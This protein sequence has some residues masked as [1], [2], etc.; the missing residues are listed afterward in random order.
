MTLIHGFRLIRTLDIPEIRSKASLY[1]HE[2]TKGEVLSLV[3]DDENK[4]FGISF[5]TPPADSTGLPHILEHSVLCGSRKYPVKEPFVELLKGSLQT[6]LN[7]FTFPD[8]TCYPVAST[9]P[10]DFENLI[11]VY[12][13]AVFHPRITPDTLRQEGWRLELPRGKARPKLMGVVYN[14]MKGAY[15]SPDNL[16][17][18]LSQQS[19]FPDTPYG[20]DSGG[21]PRRIPDLTFENFAAFHRRY[22]HPANALTFF[23]GD[24]DPTR[25][26]AILDGYFRELE[27]GQP[28]PPPALQRPFARPAFVRRPYAVSGRDQAG[29][30]LFTRN[31]ALGEAC[32]DPELHLLL[33]LLEHVLIGMPSS[34]LRKALV[35]SGLGEDLAGA[36][37]EAEI[38]QTFFSVGLKG[39]EEADLARASALIDGVLRHLAEAGPDAGDV[40]A[41]VNSLEFDLREHNTGSFP[42][43]LSL[44]LEALTT[45]LYGF[46]PFALLPFE[47]RLARVKGRIDAGEPVFQDLIRRHF[48]DN[49]HQSVVLLAPDRKLAARLARE[50]R[51][52]IRGMTAGL[53]ARG[54]RRVVR[55]TE[56]LKRLQEKPDSRKALALIPRL[57]VGDLP[58]E[59][60][61]IP[62]QTRKE[63]DPLVLF[64]DLTTSGVVYLDLGFD[65]SR[66]PDRLVP[67]APLFG[68]ALLEMGTQRRDFVALSR[69]IARRTGGIDSQTFVSPVRGQAGPAA[70]L[71]LR[72]KATFERIPDLLD[73]LR[74]VLGE[75]RFDDRERFR[76]IALEAKARAEQRL[77]PAGHAIVL[78]RLKAR[79][80]VAHLVHERM[81]GVERL[82]RLRELVG[83]IESDFAGVL[84]DLALLH[85]L[86]VTRTGLVA[87]ATADAA[88]LAALEPGL[89]ALCQGL[90]TCAAPVAERR[91]LALPPREVLTVP[92]QVNAVGKGVSLAIHGLQV[93]GQAGVV[94]RF[95]RSGYLWDRV[96]VQGG[97]YGAF[98]SLDRLGGYLAL[99]SYRDPN[100]ARTLKVFDEAAA[101]LRGLS[102]SR[103][104]LEKA[105]IGAIGDLDAY[106]LPDAKGF[107]SMARLLCG[108]DDAYRQKLR[109]E[110]LSTTRKDFR[111]FAE[112][113]ELLSR[114]GEAV[115]LG[116]REA[117]AS[118]PE[119]EATL[120]L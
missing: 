101:Y 30:A 11:D 114:H 95:L 61:P 67:L 10:R 42:R 87:N 120:V 93:K 8:K 65:L 112:A 43:G 79:G 94:A 96:R 86:L 119:A 58:R 15:S 64:H 63:S 104:E 41:A 4:V 59:N 36:G 17:H 29:L 113:L 26:L 105:V 54:L 78:S 57:T 24:F 116:S 69:W 47:E 80:H 62:S 76:Q 72:G 22:Y 51:A 12:L 107:A 45:W 9:N 1:R 14:E 115:V 85:S 99:V 33:H 110:V 81:H 77:I 5:R 102:L 92:A 40:E 68:R 83:R 28:C 82:F 38:R 6:F 103:D 27:P 117:A 55:E 84:A 50:E 71:F 32:A 100:L 66:V 98:S 108:E 25:R 21:D 52:R 89:T 31:F 35:E 73:I 37:L 56:R 70:R 109:E 75:P 53:G 106:L 20:L 23:S 60:Q 2:K 44:M 118:L 97:A 49:P 16:L 91:P 48:L 34:P 88:G 13:D 19:L 7:A 90:P 3:N 111:A 74:E 46:D 39:M 18:E